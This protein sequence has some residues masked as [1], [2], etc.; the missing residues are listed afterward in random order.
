[1]SDPFADM[2]A[3][4]RSDSDIGELVTYTGAGLVGPEQIP[5]VWVDQ[6]GQ[7]FEGPGNT[8]RT[9][10]AEIGFSALPEKPGKNDR[11]VRANGS[12]WKPQQVLTIA[13]I[14]GLECYVGTGFGVT[15]I[16]KQIADL[17]LERMTALNPAEC[18]LM[19]TADPIKFTAIHIFDH[20]Q[21][22]MPGEAGSTRYRLRL[23]IEAYFE[24]EG[25]RRPM[26]R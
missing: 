10:G 18:E 11:L 6:A 9:I 2:A 25:G 1:V 19:P 14:A 3:D 23:T 24:G 5:I 13:A 7:P 22:V 20:G 4:L 15:A 8:V 21:S 17:T 12:A 16:R 26:P